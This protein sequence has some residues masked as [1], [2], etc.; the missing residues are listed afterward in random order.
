MPAATAYARPMRLGVRAALV[1]GV[2]LG[3]DVEVRDGLVAAVGV[4]P[5]GRHGLA[6]PG[7]VDLQVNGFAGVD[8]GRADSDAIRRAGQAMLSTGVTAYQPTL[9]SDTEEN[10]TRALGAI[11]DA[12]RATPAPRVLGAHLEGPLLSPRWAGAHDPRVL[13]V[14]DLELVARLCAAGPVSSMTLAPELPGALDLIEALTSRGVV[15]WL[16]HTDADATTVNQAF[17]RGAKA[18]TH[19]YNAHR[20]FAARDP[21]PA[22]AA[23]ARPD[24]TI[25]LIADL[26]H[27][28]PEAL[29]VAWNAAPGRV[30]LVT[31]ATAAAGQPPGSYELSG[32]V[33]R[34]DGVAVVLDDGT[35]AGS[36]LTMDQAIR[37]LMSLGIPVAHAVRA[38]SAT[39]ARLMGDRSMGTLEPGSPAD[40]VVLDDAATVR[41]VL[42]GGEVVVGR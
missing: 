3:G 42:V 40:V 21:G 17:D 38:A 15:V 26:V 28:A 36:V 4:S 29:L 13:C 22:G 1:D 24:V 18:L 20:R 8:F 25:G 5:A 9:V 35:L 14:P 19:V 23:L 34:S 16:G 12:R 6:V 32:R 31:D 10:L 33:V 30:A 11:G 37:N 27:V 2:V 41:V 7:F 39:P